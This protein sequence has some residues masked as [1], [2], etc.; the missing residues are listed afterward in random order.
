MQWK[1]K[2]FLVSDN[3]QVF[4]EAIQSIESK[5]DYEK[6]ALIELL[7]DERVVLK[8][9]GLF[10][11]LKELVLNLFLHDTRIIDN[12]IAT[13]EVLVN[14]ADENETDRE[15]FIQKIWQ[16]WKGY[17]VKGELEVF[18][19]IYGYILWRLGEDRQKI[20]NCLEIV[21][22]PGTAYGNQNIKDISIKLCEIDLASEKDRQEYVVEVLKHLLK[23]SM[24]VKVFDYLE[25][26]ID[27]NYM[28]SFESILYEIVKELLSN[29]TKKDYEKLLKAIYLKSSI[30]GKEKIR[31]K[32]QYLAV[33]K[34]FEILPDQELLP[35]KDEFLNNSK[36]GIEY[37]ER[38]FKVLP[39]IVEDELCIVKVDFG[40]ILIDFANLKDAIFNNPKKAMKYIDTKIGV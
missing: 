29:S 28:G 33:E 25:T 39:E 27:D 31:E 5:R 13:G 32:F 3:F 21:Q 15:F 20:K 30:K 6:M 18:A 7:F 10:K 34:R 26:I 40:D 4:I 38:I 11:Y 22:I 16:A 23:Q 2:V 24:I 14:I 36:I 12:I 1:I 8:Q 19:P 17:M 9:E 35:V 37:L